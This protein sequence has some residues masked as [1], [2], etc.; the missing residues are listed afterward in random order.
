MKQ[1]ETN[2]ANDLNKEN[3]YLIAVTRYSL[4]SHAE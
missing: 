3:V 4:L 2:S 1:M